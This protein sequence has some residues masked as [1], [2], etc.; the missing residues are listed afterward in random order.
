MDP[1]TQD[2]LMDLETYEKNRPQIRERVVRLKK[3]RR[4]EVGSRLSLVFENRD[5]VRF[6]IQEMLRIERVRDP[7]KIQEELEI[8]NT[9]L[10]PPR[11]WSA[12]LFIEVT[13]PAQVPGVLGLLVGVEN[14]VAIEAA[15]LDWA[16]HSGGEQ[17]EPAHKAVFPPA[18]RVEG[19]AEAGRSKEEKTSSVH[20][21][22]FQPQD[23]AQWEE[24]LGGTAPVWVVVDHPHYQARQE[25]PPQLREEL[26]KDLRS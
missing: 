14:A 23:P 2:D 26:L 10:P 16:S 25:L 11:G 21:L 5:T 9:L 7:R 4:L 17:A 8:Y 13:D 3:R 20:Y 19:I 24:A 12:T 22:R 6:Q 1:L 18:L 15:R